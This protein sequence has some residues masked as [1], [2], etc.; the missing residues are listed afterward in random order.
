MFL[1][2]IGKRNCIN[3]GVY[4]SSIKE[5]QQCDLKSVR[6]FAKGD[7]LFKDDEPCTKCEGNATITRI[8][9]RKKE[10]KRKGWLRGLVKT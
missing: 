3:D 2:E 10:K 9:R 5:C 7:Y 1:T 8:H 6:E 4:C